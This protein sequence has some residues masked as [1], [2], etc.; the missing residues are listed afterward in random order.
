MAWSVTIGRFGGTAV[1]VHVTLLLFLAWIGISAWIQAGADAALTSL[2]F[3]ALI[4]ACV[5]FHEF[6]HIIA[7]RQFGIETPDVTLL[8]IGGVASLQRLPTKPGQEFIVAIAGPMVNVVIGLVLLA[9]IGPVNVG[10]TQD[11]AD[12]GVSLLSRL[13]ETNL[14]LAAFNLI[15]AFPM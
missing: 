5:V 11:I 1:R 12:P 14:L 7:A 13:A 6:G 8:P 9:A 15:P 3:I 4:F 10:L 2:V